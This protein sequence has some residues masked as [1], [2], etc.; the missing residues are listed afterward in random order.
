[1]KAIVQDRYGGP[2][3]LR[4]REVD[5]PE[6]RD[7][8]VLVRVRAASVHPDVWHVLN[9][10]PYVMRLAWGGLRRPKNRVPGTDMAGQVESV[11]KD[12]TRFRPGDAVFG[13]TVRGQPMRN[14]GAFAEYVS[15]PEDALAHKPDN[16]TFEQAA[17][18]PTSGII[19]LLNLPRDGRR[20][21][22]QH[23]L[24]NGAGGGVGAFAVQILK[25]YGATVTGVD[26]TDKL[27]MVRSLGADR[28]VD[29]TREDFT[30]SGERYSLIFDV[31]GNHSFSA[32]RRAL[33]PDGI[34]ILIG[35]DEFGKASRRW[36]G[37]VPRFL[38][39]A[40]MSA[41][42]PALPGL[43]LST[44]SKNE[45]MADLS[46]LVESGK[47]TPVVDR[48]FPLADAGEAIRYLAAGNVRGKVVL[49]A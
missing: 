6:V 27:E 40:A 17:A 48:T 39:L 26:H 20:R 37:S 11:G 44:P 38:R 35:H 2:E 13:E 4:L 22:G 43:R 23:V 42:V 33:A 5:R 34:Y 46:E 7:G 47:L 16:V 28:V 25:A 24:V 41:F 36:L 49:T 19:T 18:V 9:G 29:Y 8:E 1:M 14:G 12:V 15:V 3:I 30:R 45:L 32:C 31:P 21:P 10:Q